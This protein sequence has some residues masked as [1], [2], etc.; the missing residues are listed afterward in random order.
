VPPAFLQVN[1]TTAIGA[2]IAND[3]SANP[4]VKWSAACASSS[5]GTFN[6]TTTTNEAPS[7]YT[8]PSS[9]PSGGAVTLTATSLTDPTKSVSASINIIATAPTF[10]NGTYVFHLDGPVGSGA[11]FV[12]GVIVAQ[13]GA[14]TGGEQ[15]FI[16]YAAD[17]NDEAYL[18]EFDPI[19]GGSYST[20][21]DGNL[22]LTLKT[23]DPVVGTETMNGVII[24]SSRVLLTAVNGYG[25]SGSLDLQTSTTAPSGGYA[26]ST[27]GVDLYGQDAGIGGILNVDSAGGIS[28]SGSVI[29]V[30]DNLAFSGGLALAASKVTGP[31]Q[32]GRVVFQLA[33]LSASTFPTFYLAGYIVDSSRI[34]LVE[35]NGD[36]FQGV[37]GGTALSQGV[38]KGTFSI[39]SIAGSNYVFGMTGEGQKGDLQVAGVLSANADGTLNGTLNWNDLTATTTQNPVNFTGSY[40][41]DSTGRA[42]LSNL[43]D[44]S[45]FTY[46]LE[47]YLTGS[48]QGLLLSGSGQQMITGRAL[49]QQSGAF[50][51]ASLTGNYG[52]GASQVSSS[53]SAFGGIGMVGPI[54]VV[55]GSRTDALGGFVDFGNGPN[56]VDVTGSV[57]AATDG[58]FTGTLAGLNPSSYTTPD[59]FVF[60]LV[61]N[62]Q[63]VIIETDNTQLTLGLFELMQ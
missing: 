9:I 60:Y 63:A 21:P 42:T 6:P 1:A 54:T 2:Q 34:R 23:N 4:Q 36:N 50:S 58:I 20:T 51:A 14:I 5:C 55:A 57:T 31:D 19:S 48:G 38:N 29:D 3:V 25:G 26:F 28:G 17:Q 18:P 27:Y 13:N 45:S 15:D 35:T 8:A 49:L 12:S 32:F 24:S 37:M 61:D 11:N 47:L 56:D 59:N 53:F 46:D 52:L 40:S 33:P 30:N 62:T 41:V 7:N 43:T 16:N 39:A 10:A 22:Q 44:G